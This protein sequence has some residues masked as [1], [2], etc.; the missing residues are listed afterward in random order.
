MP[1]GPLVGRPACGPLLLRPPSFIGAITPSS[2]TAT[3]VAAASAL[4][5]PPFSNLLHAGGP[6]ALFGAERKT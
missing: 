1:A 2:D 5:E 6:E 3:V 4:Y